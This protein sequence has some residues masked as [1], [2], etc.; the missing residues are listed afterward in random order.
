MIPRSPV[1]SV[2]GIGGIMGAMSSMAVQRST[3]AHLE[4]TNADYP[5]IFQ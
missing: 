2:V 5:P 4:A 1:A 3:S